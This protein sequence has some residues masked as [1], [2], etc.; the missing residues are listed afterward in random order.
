MITLGNKMFAS[1]KVNSCLGN[2]G[3]ADFKYAVNFAVIRLVVK[4]YWKNILK[5]ENNLTA[6]NRLQSGIPYKMYNCTN[7]FL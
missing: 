3:G 6:M 2:L 1:F 4:S 5:S 7:R